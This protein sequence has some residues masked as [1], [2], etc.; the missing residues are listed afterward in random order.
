MRFTLQNFNDYDILVLVTEPDNFVNAA[1]LR[2]DF[3]NQL[4]NAYGGYVARLIKILYRVQTKFHENC[5][6]K[7][8]RAASKWRMSSMPYFIITR[9]SMPPPQAK[10]VYTLVS[11]PASCSTPGW[12]MPQPSSSIQPL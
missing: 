6:K 5:L 1:Q 9:R 12:I 4:I 7:S 10:P 3:F 8:K 11:M 2:A